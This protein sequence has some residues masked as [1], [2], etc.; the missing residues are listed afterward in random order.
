MRHSILF[1]LL[2]LMSWPGAAQRLV[3]DRVYPNSIYA[4]GRSVLTPQNQVLT[5]L[6]KRHPQ[7][8]GYF[9]RAVFLN[10]QLDTTTTSQR[11]YNLAAGIPRLALSGGYAY[12]YGEPS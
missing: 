10:R 1:A 3:R 5:A 8:P 6:F 11:V 4:F 12:T 2:L 9:G 7:M